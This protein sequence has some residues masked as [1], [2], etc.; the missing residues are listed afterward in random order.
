M[1]GGSRAESAFGNR[2]ATAARLLAPFV[3]HFIARVSFDALDDEESLEIT[4]RDSSAKPEAIISLAGV[5]HVGLSKG[6]GISGNFVDAISVI[7][8]PKA[9]LPWPE[10]AAAL[11]RRFDGLEELV[12]LRLVGPAEIDVIASIVTVYVAMSDDEASTDPTTA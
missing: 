5:R 10:E 4:L 1:T 9:P 7:H 2:C 6:P 8:L 3:G 12:W 11:V